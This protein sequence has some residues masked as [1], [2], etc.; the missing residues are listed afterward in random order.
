MRIIHKI[1][2]SLKSAIILIGILTVLSVLGTLV[3]QNLDAVEY[4]RRYPRIGHMILSLGFDDMYRSAPFRTCLWLLSISTVTCIITRWKSTYRKLSA[5]LERASAREISAYESGRPV[6]GPMKQDWSREFAAIRTD[7]DGVQ[8]CLNTSGKISLLGGMAIHI[9][10]LMVLAGGLVGVYLGVETVIRG[11]KGDTVPVAPL[12]AVRAA[13]DADRIAREAR[14]IKEFSPEDPRLNQMR[15]QI[16]ALHSVYKDGLASP[17]FKI[18]F[19]ELWIENYQA[20]DGRVIG[21]KSWNSRV[22]F[23]D[24]GHESEPVQVMVNQP[25]SYGDYTFYQSSWNKF[26]RKVK[27]KVEFIGDASAS[28]QLAINKDDFPQTLELNIKEPFKPEWSPFEFVMADFMPDFRIINDR[29]VSVSHELNNPAAM[30]VA[31]DS[32]GV[33]AGR[34]WAFPPDRMSMAGHVTN[35]PF[36]FTFISSD[37][38]YE[39]GMQM[40]HDPGK[41]MVWLGCLLFT[42]GMIMSFYVPYRESWLLVYPN[43][44]TRLVITGNRPS[45]VFADD[46]QQL[47]QQLINPDKEPPAA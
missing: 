33:V 32:A 22:R 47:D 31:Y 42:L 17:A 46:L 40:A 39:S 11:S 4:I 24:G 14:N 27:M 21:V 5:R 16:E 8:I 2:V 13:R 45:K 30:I 23:I 25:V 6:S 36:L 26:Y 35:M 15:E 9:G 18:A 34:A 10:L 20:S 38:E 28:T 3:P 41:P 12:A 29:F 19:D 44:N 43:G 1:F 37:A 7:E